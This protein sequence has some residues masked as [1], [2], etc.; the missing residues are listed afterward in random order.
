MRSLTHAIFATGQV[1]I[2]AVCR[3][4]CC[5]LYKNY[6]SVFPKTKL[7]SFTCDPRWFPGQSMRENFFLTRNAVDRSYRHCHLKVWLFSLDCD[8][9]RPNIFLKR[10]LWL[11]A[12]DFFSFK[13]WKTP[14][15]SLKT[16][17]GGEEFLF[18]YL[19]S[20]FKLWLKCNFKHKTLRSYEWMSVRRTI[21]IAVTAQNS[22]SLILCTSVGP[23]IVHMKLGFI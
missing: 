15:L 9:M 21:D 8:S 10:D 7:V 14:L 16:A 22:I 19:L 17:L 1:L 4:Y 12:S 6:F 20:I 23:S 18:S 3:S 13:W 5:G 2:Y 11:F